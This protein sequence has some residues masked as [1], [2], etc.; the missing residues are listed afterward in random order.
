MKKLLLPLLLLFPL[1]V[2]A[3][4]ADTSASPPAPSDTYR[5]SLAALISLN[6]T[7]QLLVM[8]APTAAE[9]MDAR[10]GKIIGQAY[11]QYLHSPEFFLALVDMYEPECRRLLS[12]E[13]LNELLR[14]TKSA[15][16]TYRKSL[17]QLRSNARHPSNEAI[18][19]FMQDNVYRTEKAVKNA[20]KG[21]TTK[22]IPYKVSKS[23][24]QE[25]E[26]FLLKS[27]MGDQMETLY[28][29]Y[30]SI[31]FKKLPQIEQEDLNRP[32]VKQY[33][34]DFI[35]ETII[36][37]LHKAY[38]LES[39]QNCNRGFDSPAFTHYQEAVQ[40][41]MKQP[42]LISLQEMA[43][44]V[45]WLKRYQPETAEQLENLLSAQKN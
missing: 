2:A 44:F 1:Y 40:R 45:Y 26:L 29:F 12:P 34:T 28:S 7:Q 13:E 18:V 8:L 43:A 42:L 33:L 4:G 20:K 5:D 19:T 11:R 35:R 41:T 37:T 25:G 22:I 14:W 10:Y 36:A 30:T 17:A 6:N 24:R 32:E 27:G 3:K 23:F 31:I 38:S 39:L 9:Q 21:K 15:M 16:M